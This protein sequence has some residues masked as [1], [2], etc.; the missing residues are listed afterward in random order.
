MLE[1]L[2]MTD[3]VRD[4][5]CYGATVS[6]A[7]DQPPADEHSSAERIRAAALRVLADHGVNATSFRMIADAAGVSIGL[8]Q[9][10]FGSKGRLIEAVDEYVLSAVREVVES[11]PLPPPPAD[12]LAEAGRRIV[13]LFA[14]H[15]DVVDYL[16]RAL[17][18]GG[19]IG[20]MVFDGL[21]DISVAQHEQFRAQNLT[22]P[23]LDP[24]WATLNPLI[25]RVGAIILRP[26]IE[27]RLPEPFATRSQLQ[28][29]DTA[30]TA[31]IRAGQ[32]QGLQEP[33]GSRNGSNDDRYTGVSAA[34]TM[35]SANATGIDKSGT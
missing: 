12:A 30:V 14:E 2:V 10:H 7:P 1:E 33:A 26:H 8:I 35:R 5:S 27:R 34:S 31:L 21:V 23:D 16:G 29:W 3:N 11:A 24:V 20:T 9:H 28:R 17:V 13:S 19:A 4:L 6:H 32:F 15:P 25:L 22:P 18:E